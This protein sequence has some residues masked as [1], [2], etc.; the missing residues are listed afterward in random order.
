MLEE[1]SGPQEVLWNGLSWASN[2]DSTST[3]LDSDS[4][5]LRLDSNQLN[6]GLGNVKNV[7]SRQGF[8]LRRGIQKG[9]EFAFEGGL[10]LR[11]TFAGIRGYDRK[12][13]GFPKLSIFANG[14]RQRLPSRAQVVCVVII[15]WPGNFFFLFHPLSCDLRRRAIEMPVSAS[16]PPSSPQGP[17]V[18]LGSARTP[19]TRHAADNSPHTSHMFHTRD[20]Q[21]VR[22]RSS[23]GLF[24]CPRFVTAAFVNDTPQTSYVIPDHSALTSPLRLS[25]SLSVHR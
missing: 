16:P 14:S 13:Q 12:K 24:T 1:P 11:W 22:F 5:R 17:P 19:T 21:T 7:G 23:L 25:T 3:R 4:T 15:W 9:R 18:C 20:V 10:F 2:S 6:S 8:A